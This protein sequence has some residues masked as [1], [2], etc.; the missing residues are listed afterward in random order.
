MEGIAEPRLLPLLGGEGLHWLQVEVVV[1]MEVVEILAMDEE[2]EH[3]VSL[4]THLQP[5]LNPVQLCGLEKFGCLER[6]E[7]IS[8]MIERGG[9]RVRPDEPIIEGLTSS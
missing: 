9:G 7:E 8:V 6:P 5:R 1:E 3:V 4:A 2:V